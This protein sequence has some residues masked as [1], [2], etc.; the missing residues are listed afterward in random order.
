MKPEDETIEALSRSILRDARDEAEKIQTGGKEKGDEIRQKAQKAAEAERQEI[1]DRARHGGGAHPQPGDRH[2]AVEGADQRSW[3]TAKNCWSGSSRRRR[4][5]FP[6]SRSAP[7][8]RRSSM[9][10]LREA[11]TQLNASKVSLRADA[12][13]Q[14]MLKGAVE[15]FSKD[16]DLEVS[17]QEPLEEG[18]GVVVDAS[19]GHLHFDNTLETRL[20]RQKNSLR[21]AV[22]QVLMGEKL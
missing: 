4:R 1:L 9:R 20:E 15:A 6:A 5:K 22:Y 17:W 18:M 2:G 10:L 14:K 8:T 3:S 19:D 12:E 13:T 21:S 16:H 7:I 11:V